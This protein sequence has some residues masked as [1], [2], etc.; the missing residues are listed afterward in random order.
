MKRLFVA[1]LV[2]LTSLHAEVTLR[3]VSSRAF[4]SYF[5]MARH[6][7]M[8]PSSRELWGLDRSI[9]LGTSQVL[10]ELSK[11][12]GCQHL[13]DL[14]FDASG[15][16][17]AFLQEDGGVAVWGVRD[18]KACFRQALSPAKFTTGAKSIGSCVTLSPDGRFVAVTGM[19]T[20]AQ[21]WEIATGKECFRYAFPVIIDT[22][23]EYN[24]EL[25][26]LASF[27]LDFS[28]DGKFLAYGRLNKLTIIDGGAWVRKRDL[29]LP[30]TPVK[31]TFLEPEILVVQLRQANSKTDGSDGALSSRVGRVDL[32]TGEYR[33]APESWTD[34]Q[35]SPDG[36]NLILVAGGSKSLAVAD[37]ASLAVLCEKR[38][39]V[40]PQCIVFEGPSTFSVGLENASL[41]TYEIQNSKTVVDSIWGK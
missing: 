8:R 34:Y 35:T 4:P 25:S 14:A 37:S 29:P 23:N 7:F 21:V 36:K 2:S 26:K 27:G 9:D 32:R 41:V 18:A 11:R 28:P 33:L 39:S 12:Y 19:G 13:R 20:L 17:V 40:A 30:G 31:I 10:V 24:P 15:N 6:A 3:E 1:A 16:L 5:R 22:W 38:L